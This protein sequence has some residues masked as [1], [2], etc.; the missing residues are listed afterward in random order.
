VGGTS[1]LD[2]CDMYSCVRFCDMINFGVDG[3]DVK[4]YIEFLGGFLDWKAT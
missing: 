3:K 2:F 1:S 4:R